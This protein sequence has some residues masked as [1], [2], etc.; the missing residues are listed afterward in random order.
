MLLAE[1]FERFVEHSPL[2]VMV[3]GILERILSPERLDELFEQTAKTGYTRE[4]LFS[5]VV[6]L[7]SLV[8]CSIRPSVGA[9][10]KAMAPEIGVSKTAVY[11]KLKGIEPQVSAALVAYIASELQSVIHQLGGELPPLLAGYRTLILDGNQLGAT[12]HRLK[13]LGNTSAAALPGKSLVLF[14]QA[15]MLAIRVFPC[16]DGHAQER[17]LF[18]QV[19]ATVAPQQLY[20]A[21]RN[22]CTLPFLFGLAQKQAAFVIREHKIMPQQALEA[23]RPLGRVDSGE[24]FEQ[25]VLL[26]Y[27]DRELR[28]RRILLKL[29]Q[30]TRNGDPE[31]A[32]LCNLPATVANATLVSQLYRKRWTLETVFQVITE[33]FH[34]EIKTLSYPRAAL[35]SFCMA[36]VAYNVLSCVKAALRSVHGEGKIEA[37]ISNY[38]LADEI[39]GTYRGMMI[40]VPPIEWQ[41]FAQMTLEQFCKQLKYLADKVQLDLFSSSPRGPKKKKPKPT[42][43]PNHPHVSTAR[44]LA[45]AKRKNSK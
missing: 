25:S 32:L 16:E 23:L 15:L 31:I 34:C 37:G 45:Q 38:Y 24:L 39:E 10:Y 44:L 7:M 17:S 35:F 40:A 43:D 36:L 30:P 41:V 20:I 27:E 13:V 9:V 19:L 12:E 29:D 5:T 18:N 14:D 33:T 28:V 11:D 21:D 4:L 2:T 1:I 6:N 22:M 3:R 42:Y 26:I 8:V